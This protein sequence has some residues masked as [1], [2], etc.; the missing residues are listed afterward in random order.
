[1]LIRADVIM[2]IRNGKR[3]VVPAL[4]SILADEALGTLIIVDDGSTDD[5]ETDATPWLQ[6]P[7]VIVLRQRPSGIA[8]ALNRALGAS[9]STYVARMDA[10]DISLPGRL[11]AQIRHLDK[12]PSLAAIGT[13]VEFISTGFQSSTHS[14]YP[15]GPDALHHDLFMRGRCSVSHSSV[16]LRRT[17]IM[18][19]GGYRESYL[20]AEDYDLWLRLS[21][22]RAIANMETCFLRYRIH[23]E[24]VSQVQRIRQCFTRDLALLAARER[25]A[26]RPD[27]TMGWLFARDY[28]ELQA[29]PHHPVIQ[30]LAIAY[31]AIDRF[32]NGG[33]DTLSVDAVR[34]IPSL[35]R[36][37]YLGETRRMRYDLIKKAAA[38]AWKRGDIG[39]AF[40]AYFA[41]AACRASDSKYF[42]K[43]PAFV[44]EGTS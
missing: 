14:S 41:L 35:A 25:V 17:A 37:S 10:D 8:A 9:T 32:Y 20:H 21:E 4:Q 33:Q 3:F 23:P 1:M 12:H 2:P 42:R 19:A 15:T 34:A 13:Q 22:S 18:E 40:E 44:A 26:G 31:E 11:A 29:S 5:W 36:A 28:A 39:D 27:P 6:S 24:Q 38:A 43:K 30:K 16:M 7:S